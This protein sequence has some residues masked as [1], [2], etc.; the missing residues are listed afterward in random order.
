M[1]K[2]TA[3][4]ETPEAN[5]ALARAAPVLMRDSDREMTILSLSEIDTLGRE[6]W[7]CSFCGKVCNTTPFDPMQSLALVANR[8]RKPGETPFD[9]DEDLAPGD[10]MR[11][12]IMA[13][14]PMTLQNTMRFKFCDGHCWVFHLALEHGLHS[15]AVAHVT[16]QVPA[17]RPEHAPMEKQNIF[18]MKVAQRPP[19]PSML[20]VQAGA[21]PMVH[22]NNQMFSIPVGAPPPASVS[23]ATF[24]SSESASETPMES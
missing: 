21:S 12:G 14:I 1:S 7:T 18:R 22:A 6:Q 2:Q 10:D 9:T 4:H 23:S 16:T 19:R 8:L 24:Y 15:Y 17:Y 11:C 13:P 3:A 20:L 5:A